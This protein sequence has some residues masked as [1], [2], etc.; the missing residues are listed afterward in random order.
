MSTAAILLA[1][2]SFVALGDAVLALYLRRK[3]DAI[4]S[5]EALDD[6]E[7]D[8]ASLRRAAAIMFVMSPLMFLAG[9]LVAFGTVPIPGLDPISR[10]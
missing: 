9:V 8:P 2:L 3:A 1:V 4:E 10:F 6:G 7:N 5:G